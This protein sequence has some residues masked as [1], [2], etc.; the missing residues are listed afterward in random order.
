MIGDDL[1]QCMKVVDYA[2]HPA[3][4]FADAEVALLEDV[5]FG[6]EL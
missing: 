3:T 2:L 5:E 4:V 1:T 6:I